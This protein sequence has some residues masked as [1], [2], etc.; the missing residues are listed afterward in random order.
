M[1]SVKLAQRKLMETIKISMI[2][3][4]VDLGVFTVRVLAKIL[5]EIAGELGLEFEEVVV[6]PGPQ[7]KESA[8]VELYVNGKPVKKLS[9]KTAVSGII[10][11]AVGKLK[12]EVRDGEDGLVIAFA[13]AEGKKEALVLLI[14][15][16]YE[17]LREFGSEET[18]EAIKAKIEEKAVREGIESLYILALNEAILFDTAYRVLTIQ[19]S[20]LRTEKKAN[21]AWE[22]AGKAWEEAKKARE[23]SEKVMK[24]L[25]RLVRELEKRS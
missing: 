23:A 6:Y 5:P 21:E 8:D 17:T 25:E 24:M 10:K 9:V 12:R 20:I 1:A 15:I 7:P 3:S 22:I 11:T 4:P 2:T 19:E 13:A 16:P 18:A 14:Y